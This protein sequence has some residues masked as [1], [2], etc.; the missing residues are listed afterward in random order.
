M[1]LFALD[2]VNCWFGHFYLVGCCLPVG[3]LI[4]LV[5]MMICR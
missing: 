5:F 2:C 3:F 1:L 4:D